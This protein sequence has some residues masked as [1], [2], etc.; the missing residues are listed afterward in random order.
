M[1]DFFI[2]N[3]TSIL[4]IEPV[5][6]NETIIRNLC[7]KLINEMSLYQENGTN[8]EDIRK[9]RNSCLR[10]IRLLNFNKILGMR[11][12]DCLFRICDLS[13]FLYNTVKASDILLTGNGLT[14]NVQKFPPLTCP[15]DTHLMLSA[16][17]CLIAVYSK[18]YTS[19][20]I[21]FTCSKS[22]TATL[23]L[24]YFETD[25]LTK[26]N[27]MNIEKEIAVLRKTASL[28]RGTLLGYVCK[29]TACICLS[30]KTKDNEHL[31][32]ICAPDYIDLL[33]DKTSDIY[34]GMSFIEEK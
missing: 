29:S 12:S 7:H 15:F 14:A 33:T 5:K 24:A 4:S 6:E 18:L 21:T 10:H 20:K 11:E 3:L 34:T 9:I 31:Q 23:L 19:G 2:N 16:V 30:I 32:V 13:S 8:T 22:G 27:H 17:T 28:H 26:E 1:I 25:N